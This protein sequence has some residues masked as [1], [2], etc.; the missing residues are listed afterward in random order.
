MI[1][2]LLF[3]PTLV[4]CFKI[5]EENSDPQGE[6][7]IPELQADGLRLHFLF[8]ESQELWS[9]LLSLLQLVFYHQPSSQT[10][11]FLHYSLEITP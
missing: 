9:L 5:R 6:L 10:C 2:V 11:F 4:D 1:L 3:C 7:C 8:L